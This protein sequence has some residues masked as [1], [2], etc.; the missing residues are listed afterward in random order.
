MVE[1][2][3]TNDRGA[4]MREAR[5]STREWN[6]GDFYF[7]EP[8]EEVV[9]PVSIWATRD[10]SCAGI[11]AGKQIAMCYNNGQSGQGVD[12]LIQLI[13]H[14]GR[15]LNADAGFLTEY[16]SNLGFKEICRGKF[17]PEFFPAR[18]DDKKHGKP[19]V[20]FMAYDLL[21]FS[22]RK[23]LPA[24]YVRTWNEAVILM[25]SIT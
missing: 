12:C 3:R 13:R 15:W 4:F 23:E 25:D 6:L 22:F 20:V 18:W 5:K 24:G 9:H 1:F 7:F 19:D 11:L 2:I 21:T 8:E 10:W 14:G 16:Y 17:G